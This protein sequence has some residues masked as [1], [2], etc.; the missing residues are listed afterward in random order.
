VLYVD[1]DAPSGGDGRSWGAALRHLQDAFALARREPV[2]EIRIAQG[3]YR[4]DQGGGWTALDRQA[5]FELVGGVVTKGGFGGVTERDPDARD[6]TAFVTIFSGDLLGN[7]GPDPASY[8]DNAYRVIRAVSLNRIAVLDGVTVTASQR[9]AGEPLSGG[10]LFCSDSHVVVQDCRFERNWAY[11]GAGFAVTSGH[12]DFHRTL[13][14]HNRADYSAGGDVGDE[15]SVLIEDCTFTSNWAS[16]HEAGALRLG[17]NDVVRRCVFLSNGSGND[18]GGVLGG[19]LLEDC[20]FVGNHAGWLGGAVAYGDGTFVRCSFVNNT[21]FAR[22]GAFS[23]NNATLTNNHPGFVDCDFIN[24]SC[25]FGNG[26]AAN[27]GASFVNCRFLNNRSGVVGGGGGNATGGAVHAQALTTLIANC[28]FSGNQ[29]EGHGGAVFVI[30]G[31]AT[32]IINSTFANNLSGFTGQ[33]VSGA[34][35]VCN[36]VFGPHSA[37]AALAG[38]TSLEYSCL[39]PGS[40]LPPGAGVGN[41]IADPRFVNPLGP[42]GIAGTED[43]DLRLL[44]DSPCIDAGNTVALP[45]DTLDLDNDGDTAEPLP[46]DLLGNRRALDTPATPD[47]GVPPPPPAPPHAIVDMGAMEYRRPAD[48]APTIGDGHVDVDDLIAVILDWGP[49][50]DE[51]GASRPAIPPPCPADIDDDGEVGVADLIAVVLGWG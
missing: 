7:D 8:S 15:G 20:W 46:L 31:S 1:D 40:T 29:A 26:G 30:P 11:R 44:A 47:T 21:A 35:E 14:I 4:P 3:V 41:I 39:P 28:T 38:I 24:N 23:S 2:A 42:D 36:S 25:G 45:A 19:A 22:G 43:D 16:P 17:G 5:A 34:A 37:G 33:A 49:C 13:F 18:G 32:S 6:L 12:I 50:D 48:I 27:G 10:G 51:G 9:E